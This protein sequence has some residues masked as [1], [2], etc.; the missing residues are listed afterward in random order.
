MQIKTKYEIGQK[1]FIED[2]NLKGRIIAIHY[3]HYVEY[4]V[5]YF[6][7]QANEVYF[8]EEELRKIV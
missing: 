8:L 7:G 4:F 2:L 1:V 6:D 3:V 5:R